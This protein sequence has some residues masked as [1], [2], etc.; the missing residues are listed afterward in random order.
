[1]PKCP[2]YTIIDNH[3]NTNRI[4]LAEQPLIIARKYIVG[5]YYREFIGET[6]AEAIAAMEEWAAEN[7]L[8]RGFCMIGKHLG[9]Y[10]IFIDDQ[11]R[12]FLHG[13]YDGNGKFRFVRNGIE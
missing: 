13:L 9:W 10:D 7:T 4:E 3:C 12:Q 5:K 2:E 1:M 8:Y 11:G 6:N